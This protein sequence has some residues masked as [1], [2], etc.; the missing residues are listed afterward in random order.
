MDV[1]GRILR[2][3]KPAIHAGMTESLPMAKNPVEHWRWL[4][5]SSDS[6]WTNGRN[7]END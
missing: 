6:A 2:A 1:S 4:G 5:G 3:G 7:F